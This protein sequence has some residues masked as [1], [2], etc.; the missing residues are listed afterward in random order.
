M[1]P[2]RPVTAAATVTIPIAALALF[3]TGQPAY[4][5]AT[6]TARTGSAATA[7]VDGALRERGVLLERGIPQEHGVLLEGGTPQKGGVLLEGGVP[8]EQGGGDGSTGTG[9][10]TPFG[11]VNVP[12]L[13]DSVGGLNAVSGLGTARKNEG[14]NEGGDRNSSE[15]GGSSRREDSSGRDGSSSGRDDS[16]GRDNGSGRGDSSG[17]DAPRGGVRTGVGG[18]VR[19]DTTQIAAGAGVLAGAA[20]GGAWLLRRRASGTQGAG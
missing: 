16:S 19:S 9:R 2:A 15:G 11:G 12:S 14:S 7:P 1:R 4:A 3:A 6:A 5:G 8:R 10:D 17:S 20:A 18:S 13:L